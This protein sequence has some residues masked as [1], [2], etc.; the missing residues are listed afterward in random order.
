MGEF[1]ITNIGAADL[2][3]SDITFS[4]SAF[5]LA[6]TPPTIIP[7]NGTETVQVILTGT[8]AGVFFE[9]VSILSNDTDE[10]IFNFNV[11]GE[12]IG[13]DIAVYDG[14]DIYSD[15]EILD[16]QAAPV[17]FGSGPDGV[18]IILPITIA[19]L[20]P[21]DLNISNITI[22]GSTFSL[23]SA[24]PTFVAAEVD[25]IISFV[26][27]DI[28][29]SGASA[30][31]FTETVTILSDDEDEPA[32][33]FTLT[34]TITTSACANVPTATVGTIADICENG[35]IQLSGSF[36]G[37]AT[38]ASWSTAGDGGFDNAA[39]LNAVYTPGTSDIANGSV[40]FT[41]TTND[42][43]GAG[44]CVAASAGVSVAI[45]STPVAGSPVVQSTIALASNVNVIG[46]STVASGDV[47]TVTILQN[48]TK[49][50][51]VVK[52][53]K[54]IDYTAA[55]GT[56]GADSFQYTICNQCSLCS[57]GT[58]GVNILNAAPVITPPATTIT[59]VAGQ[60]VTIPF[61]SFISD[62][63]DNIDFN[64]IQ[65]INGPTSNAMATF[66]ASFN[67]IMDYSNTPFVGIDQITIQVCDL[68]SACSQIV[69]TIEVS[70]DII[71]YN[72]VSPNGDGYND[73]FEIKN[74][75]FLEPTNNVTIYNRW[76]DKVFEMENYDSLNPALRFEGR[77]NNGKEL[78]SGVYFYKV[79]F[80]SGRKDL[81]GY[82]T[83]KK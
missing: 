57:N 3:I 31:T 24:P 36:G 28:M 66:D 9:T 60:S 20:N 21:A 42:P 23:T 46:A 2:N 12:I 47:L 26:T 13:P 50:T 65:I 58:V 17:D 33:S 5:S 8:N 74:I 38:S 71:P 34:G 67:L 18:D 51:A 63:N 4:G 79:E 52:A 59:S 39:L 80:L 64:S 78:P 48:P 56:I 10:A 83:L 40:N 37:A 35:T 41:L 11:H 44:P 16:G 15:P 73:H 32:F 55:A 43:D 82:I 69:L 62:L 49:G 81:T 70:G 68:L 25:A 27:F 72:G 19:N 1:T 75:Q 14:T 54:T 22:T 61:I 29:L 53:D 6:S 76:G 30:G 77:Q 7:V 45:T